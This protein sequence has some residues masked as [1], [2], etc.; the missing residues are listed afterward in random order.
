M[1]RDLVVR[2]SAQHDSRVLREEWVGGQ[3][4]LVLSALH[5]AAIGADEGQ[6]SEAA[7]HIEH[8]VPY[9]FLVLFRHAKA[10]KSRSRGGVVLGML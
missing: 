7:A 1:G 6:L 9:E 2:R 3:R 4:V 8:L 10:Q 5:H